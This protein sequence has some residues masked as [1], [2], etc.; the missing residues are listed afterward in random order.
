MKPPE[1]IETDHL[2]LRVPVLEDAGAIFRNYAQD[3]D[4]TRYLIWQPHVRI[5]QTQE[6]LLS[7]VSAWQADKRFPY[8]ITEIGKEIAIGMIEVRLDGYK[9]E[10]GYVLG[11][12][13]WGKGYMTEALRVV[14]KWCLD[15]PEIY[16]IWAVCD[17]ENIASAR[18]MEKAGM[19]REGLLRRAIFH[20]NISNE[21]RDS[22]IY[23]ITR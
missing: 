11:R 23:S 2:V 3:P 8:V 15:Q 7:C 5:E 16:R 13:Y 10:V 20:P 1:Y 6:F 9:A 21:P 14:I 12:E 18:I 4:V 17:V 19:H 22:Y